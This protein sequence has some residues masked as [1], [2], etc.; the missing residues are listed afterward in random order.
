M[1]AHVLLLHAARLTYVHVPIFLGSPFSLFLTIVKTKAN[2]ITTKLHG[3]ADGV[4][5]SQSFL[6]V[7]L[8]LKTRWH[9]GN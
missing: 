1:I 2:N 4:I 3:S 5:M 8:A 6:Y 7:Y 9:V